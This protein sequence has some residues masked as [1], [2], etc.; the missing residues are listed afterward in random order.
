MKFVLRTYTA[1][2]E[3]I[4][5]VVTLDLYR[6]YD[7][8]EKQEMF[9]RQKAT[10]PSLEEHVYSNDWATF[11]QY[12]EPDNMPEPETGV[13]RVSDE[14]EI[15][16]R[17]ISA[18]IPKIHVSADFVWF[19]MCRNDLWARIETFVISNTTMHLA[20]TGKDCT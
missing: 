2:D 18:N 10:N 19:S 13:F 14:I 16:G 9:R 17:S 7:I 6:L 12:V 1:D 5:A 11:Y 15:Q 20:T 3:E 8:T 4:Y